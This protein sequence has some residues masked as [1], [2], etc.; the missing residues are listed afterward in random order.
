M[1]AKTIV[2]FLAAIACAALLLSPGAASASNGP[3]S[4]QIRPTIDQGLALRGTNGFQIE[5]TVKNRRRLT[6]AAQ[7]SHNMIEGA[8]YTL[9][10]HPRRGSDDIVA[11]LGKLGRID[12]RF[13]PRKVKESKPPHDCRGGKFVTEEGHFVGLIVFRGER[14][15][16]RV[17]AHRAFGAISRTPALTC[18]NTAAKSRKHA[19]HEREVL[20]HTAEKMEN[21]EEEGVQA[22]GLT[23]I[24]RG[25]HV[26]LVASRV[27]TPEKKGKKLSLANVVVVGSRRRGRIEERSEVLDLL[28]VGSI[29]R[30]RDRRLPTEEAVLAPPAPFSGSAT[31]RR[32]PAKPPS[33]SGD[34][35][36]DLPGLGPVRLAGHGVRASK[37]EGFSCLLRGGAGQ[38]L[39]RRLA[40]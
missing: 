11:D 12:V 25:H 38:S 8:S 14:G 10:I 4:R 6:L 34:L 33:W 15:Y 22:D 31:F 26:A 35:K 29:F 18:R 27:S 16:T 20:E 19:R 39:L 36:V 9:R 7:R 3:A 32:H 23:A 30:V 1:R 21:E 24:A 5:V 17:R 40:N 2:A 13:V 28:D 37:C